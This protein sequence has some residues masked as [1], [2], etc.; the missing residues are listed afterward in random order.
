MRNEIRYAFRTLLRDRGFALMVVLSLAVGIGAN[1]AIFSL[2][3]GVLLRAPDFPNPDRLVTLTQFAPKLAKAYPSLPMNIAIY[4]EW[5]KQLTTLESIGIARA[6][7]FNLTGSGQP[8]QVRGALV[9]ASIFRVFG[10]QP[11]LGR[12][13]TDEEDAAGRDHVVVIADALW[14]RRFQA[15]P[16]VIGRKMLLDGEPCEVVGVLPATFHFPREEKAGTRFLGEGLEVY[17]PLGYDAG[18]LKIRMGDFN[19]WATARLK[20][21]VSPARAQA[22]L[23]VVQAGISKQI[24]GDFDLHATLMPLM[25]RMVGEVRQGLVLLMA[26]VGVVL[27][28]LCVNLANLSLARAAGRAREAAIRTAL[29]ASRGRL[30]RQSLVESTLLALIG[31]VLG[32]TL[33]YFGVHAL[34]AAAPLDL[35]RLDEV[36]LD[37]PVLL[38]A[39][40]ISLGTGLLFGAL[41]AL[42]SA[43]SAPFETLKSGS[44]SNTEGRGGLRVRNLLVSLEVGLSAALLVTAGLLIASFV[45][46]MSV[47]KGFNVERVLAVNVSLLSTKYPKPAARAEFFDRLLEK[48]RAMPGVQ[49]AALVSALPMT[50]ETWIDIVGMEH[51]PR[52]MVEL[53]PANVRFISPGYFQALRVGLRD[54]RDFAERDR[55][56]KVAI[57]SAALA[58]RIWGNQNPIGRKLQDVGALL[59]VVG[60]TPDIRSTGLDQNPVNMIYFPYWQRPQLGS[61]ILLRSAMDPRALAGSLRAAVWAIDGEVTVPQVRTLEEVMSRSVSQRRFQMLLVLLFAGAALALAA[62]GT[63]GVLSYAVTRR[64]AEMGIR[65]ALGAAQGDV[66]RMVLRQGMMPVMA[67]LVAGGLAAIAVGAYVESLLFQV[68]PRDPLAFGVSAAVLLTVSVAACLIPARRATRVNPIDALRFE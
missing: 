46:V 37:L 24:P 28:V 66:L 67:G 51:D 14:R 19:Y 31:G 16:G 21:G 27:L 38:F 23:N 1:T 2:I 3:N 18:D 29:G 42:R 53:P 44:R 13:F 10:V 36:S 52:P 56:S 35:P 61:A 5:R 15:D 65:M 20:P 4:T 25:E 63:Y 30:V 64:T 60:V 41:P 6:S 9:S 26:A 48:A 11:H 62:F 58:Q 54:G 45:R 39:L 50:G 57:V 32:V 40:A 22:E 68:S 12:V 59:E 7:V 34:L 47:D 8:E 55:T 43:R 49:D 17:R 33:A